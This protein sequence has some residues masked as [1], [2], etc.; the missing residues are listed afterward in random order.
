MEG[1]HI[2]ADVL[3]VKTLPSLVVSGEDTAKL[4]GQW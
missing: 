2:P 4:G 1:L 3:M